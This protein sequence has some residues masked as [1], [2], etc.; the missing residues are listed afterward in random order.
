M[1]FSSSLEAEHW[2]YA[3]GYRQASLL[4]SRGTGACRLDCEW[5]K[6]LWRQVSWT[7]QYD[8]GP[9]IAS[10]ASCYHCLEKQWQRA[11]PLAGSSEMLSLETSLIC[12]FRCLNTCS[13]LIV[14]FFHLCPFCFSIKLSGRRMNLTLCRAWWDLITRDSKIV[15][16]Y[17][18][19]CQLQSMLPSAHLWLGF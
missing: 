19:K 9:G 2:C 8:I 6:H 18:H 14:T 10:P 17:N 15:T 12:T 5:V 13:H 11:W 3:D 7:P 4:C 16:N 1:E